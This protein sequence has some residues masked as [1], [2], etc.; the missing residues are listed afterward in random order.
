MT[1]VLQMSSNPQNTE[2]TVVGNFTNVNG[3]SR[4][5]I[6]KFSLGA[7]S[8]TLSP[9]YTNLFTQACSSKFDTYMTDVEYSPNGQ[10]LVVSTTGAYG[11]SASSKR[12][13]RV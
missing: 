11:G 3:T 9:W 2:L 10:F 4:P 13:L 7:S 1:D 5:Q 12:H 8:A 6:A